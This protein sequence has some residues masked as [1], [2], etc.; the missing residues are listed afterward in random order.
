MNRGS[1]S[2]AAPRALRFLLAATTASALAIVAAG[3]SQEEA[4]PVVAKPAPTGAAP[5]AAAPKPK[6]P[7]PV[8]EADLP[9]IPI[10]P[11]YKYYIGGPHLSEDKYGRH[12][13]ESFNDEVAQPPSRGMVFGVKRDGD[14]VE[15]KV[16]A[17]GRYVALNRGRMI[18]GHF[19]K[20]YY[21]GFKKEV[22]VAREKYTHDDEK[23]VTRIV[24]EEFDYETGELIRTKEMEM[25]YLPA[26]VVDDEEDE[27]AGTAKPAA[28]TAPA[29]SPTAPA[30]PPAH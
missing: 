18:D 5:G 12:R 14:K 22:L 10:E 2:F 28:P 11:G 19:W 6:G 30:A 26:K 3:C 29:A 15:Y 24:T 25:N 1:R 7:T 17:N 23:K 13:I 4:P 27:D 16:W 9:K 8:N 21:E 20:D